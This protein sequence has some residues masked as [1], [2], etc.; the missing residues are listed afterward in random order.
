MFRRLITITT[1]LMALGCVA[2]TCALA[3]SPDGRSPDTKDAAAAAH[4]GIAAAGMKAVLDG[5]SPDTKDAALSAQSQQPA[6][7]VSAAGFDGRSPDTRDAAAAAH[8]GLAPIILSDAGGFDWVDALIG[9]AA[10]FGL[11]LVAGAGVGLVRER[12]RV[13]AAS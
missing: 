5:R 13:V 11:A 12:H 4:A 8:S 7:L 2:A 10:G 6:T 1:M 9:A 3:G